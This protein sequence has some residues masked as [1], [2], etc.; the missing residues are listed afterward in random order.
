MGA[1]AA[2]GENLA[3]FPHDA[4]TQGPPLERAK[5][6]AITAQDVHTRL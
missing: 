4:Y 1:H 5:A 3:G 2:V 6:A